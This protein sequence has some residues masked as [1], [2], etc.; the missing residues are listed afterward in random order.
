MVKVEQGVLSI[1]DFMRLYSDEGPFEWIDGERVP[2]NPQITRS[3][4]I[5]VR[6]L[7]KLADHVD[8]NQL[9]EAFMETPFVLPTGENHDGSKGLAC[10]SMFASAIRLAALAK[11]YPDWEDMPLPLVPDL[12]VEVIS[13]SDK[14]S[15]VSK[16]IGRYLSDGVQLIWLIDPEPKVVIVYEQGSDQQTTLGVDRMLAGGEVIPGFEMSIASL[17]G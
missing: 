9:G 17:F 3:G 2:V 8:A 5:A 1:E 12:V 4:R 13:P 16:K 11:E 6:L 15:D 14:F 7:R 10:R